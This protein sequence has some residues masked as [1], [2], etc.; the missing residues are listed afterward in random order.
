MRNNQNGYILF[1]SLIGMVIL[2]VALLSLAA[3]F[4]QTTKGTLATDNLTKAAYIANDQLSRLKVHDGQRQDRNSAV[5][6]NNVILPAEENHGTVFSVT[7]GVVPADNLPPGLIDDVI[8]VQA[9]VS[10]NE[11]T[12][13]KQLQI[14]TYYYFGAR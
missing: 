1:D 8:P 4:M 6:A 12:E 11:S 13:E 7:T 9:T 14:I 3:L 2:S 10:W 5:W